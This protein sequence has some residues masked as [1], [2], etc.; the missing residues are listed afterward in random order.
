M[1]EPWRA[2]PLRGIRGPRD[3]L[4]DLRKDSGHRRMPRA[5]DSGTIV[6]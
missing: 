1:A 3:R 4:R 2:E 5:P 6:A